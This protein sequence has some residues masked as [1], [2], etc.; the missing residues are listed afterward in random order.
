MSTY[1]NFL[2]R[3]THNMQYYSNSRMNVYVNS[4]VTHL[5]IATAGGGH[6]YVLHKGQGQICSSHIAR[7]TVNV[8]VKV[9]F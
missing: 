1:N 8:N 2:S 9:T 4:N 5:A 7:V 3:Y 6:I